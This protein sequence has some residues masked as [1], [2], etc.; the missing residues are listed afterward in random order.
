[1]VFA[2]CLHVGGHLCDVLSKVQKWR[3]AGNLGRKG[4]VFVDCVGLENANQRH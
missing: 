1:M 3:S 4:V 2:I